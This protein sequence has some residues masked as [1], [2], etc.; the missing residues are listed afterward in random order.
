MSESHGPALVVHNNKVFT[1]EDF[2]N[3][4]KLAAGTK[5]NKNLKIGKFGIGFCSVY[6]ITDVPSFVSREWLYIFDPTLGYLREEIKNPALPGKKLQFTSQIVQKSRQL[7]P[8]DKLYG[9]NRRDRYN[10]TMF[11][12]P[13][14]KLPSELSDRLYTEHTAL[15]L[16]DDIYNC[17]ENLILFLQHIKTITF[18]RINNGDSKPTTSFKIRK[19]EISLPQAVSQD[20]ISIVSVDSRKGRKTTNSK[21]LVSQDRIFNGSKLAV[22]SVV[23]ELKPDGASSK[24][25]VNKK[26]KGEVFCYLPLSQETGLPVHVSCNFAVINNRRGIWTA[27]ESSITKEAE[28]EWNIFLM[29]MVFQRPT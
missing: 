3:I 15:K 17:S 12:L 2:E 21:W 4:T 25:H 23:C 26:L 24:H 19:K 29:E 22:S 14:R 1:D 18:Q 10:G 13:F 27:D 7:D 8:Y 20:G 5:Q 6:H 16:Q 11:R 28:V 9:F